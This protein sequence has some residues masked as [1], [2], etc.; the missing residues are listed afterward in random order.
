MKSA[1]LRI[2]AV[3]IAVQIKATARTARS[4][5]RVNSEVLRPLRPRDKYLA[6]SLESAPSAQE[7][8]ERPRRSSVFRDRSEKRQHRWLSRT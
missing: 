1:A 4:P 2:R 3:T 7:F 5:F 6:G 8:S